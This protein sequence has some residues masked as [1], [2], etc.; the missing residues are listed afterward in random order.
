MLRAP[1]DLRAQAE[2]RNLADE[3]SCIQVYFLEEALQFFRVVELGVVGK[4]D[5]YV[6]ELEV[7]VDDALGP[8]VLAAVEDLPQ[9][10]SDVSLG[11][12]LFDFVKFQ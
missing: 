12:A 10:L 8:E 4:V 5:E 11:Q 1:L 7:P 6:G 3:L 2:V 9:N